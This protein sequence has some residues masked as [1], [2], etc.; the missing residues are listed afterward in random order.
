VCHAV[1]EAFC[2]EG[3]LGPEQCVQVEAAAFKE[4]K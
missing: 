1:H 3:D 4:T 2:P